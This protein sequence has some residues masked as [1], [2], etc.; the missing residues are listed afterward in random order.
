MDERKAPHPSAAVPGASSG[1]G[2]N[3]ALQ[4]EADVVTGWRNKAQRVASKVLPA[5]A[6]AQ[7][8]RKNAEPGSG[9]QAHA[10]AAAEHPSMEDK[11]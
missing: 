10:G 11:R 5:H 2:C 6:V 8:H 9:G 1:I 7:V 3:L 4:G